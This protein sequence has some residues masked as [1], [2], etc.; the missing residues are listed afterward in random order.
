[1]SRCWCSE[2]VHGYIAGI[3]KDSDLEPHVY[4]HK[5]ASRP[6][7]PKRGT[8]FVSIEQR[9]AT[10]EKELCFGPNISKM[11]PGNTAAQVHPQ[12]LLGEPLVISVPPAENFDFL[13]S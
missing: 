11:H 3:G 13:T 2:K 8:G 7:V 10:L 6:W 5:A 9:G 4:D 1:M 12:Q